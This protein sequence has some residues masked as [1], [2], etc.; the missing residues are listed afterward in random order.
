MDRFLTKPAI[1]F[2]CVAY[3]EYKWPSELISGIMLFE[4]ETIT[5]GEFMYAVGIFKGCLNE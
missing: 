1:I 3:H 4:G 5:V 2:R